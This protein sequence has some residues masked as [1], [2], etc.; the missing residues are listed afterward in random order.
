MPKVV[1]LVRWAKA[2]SVLVEGESLAAIE[3]AAEKAAEE[4]DLDDLGWGD[5]GEWK[6]TSVL[7]AEGPMAKLVRQGVNSE[8]RIVD[9]ED[10]KD[11]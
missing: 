4:G 7:I 5:T 11:A 3:E 10:V 8:G 1:A 9:R 2:T 6:V